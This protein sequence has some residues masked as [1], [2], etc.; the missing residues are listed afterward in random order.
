M[1]GKMKKMNI[2]YFF[3]A[4]WKGKSKCQRRIEKM[5]MITRGSFGVKTL[6]TK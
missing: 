4:L 1:E 2:P 3:G 5:A 6:V